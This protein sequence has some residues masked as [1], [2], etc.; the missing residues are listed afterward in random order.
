MKR[1]FYGALLSAVSFS[2]MA[3][4]YS[5]QAEIGGRYNYTD[6]VFDDDDSYSVYGSYYF[7]PVQLKNHAYAEAA[8]LERASSV[9]LGGTFADNSF[10]AYNVCAASSCSTVPKNL[11]S[12]NY[13]LSTRGYVLDSI[14]YASA[15]YNY[16]DHKIEYS[17]GQSHSGSDTHWSAQLGVAPLEGWLLTTGFSED[18]ALFED[19][20]NVHSKYVGEL[21]NGRAYNLEAG[22]ADWDNGDSSWTVGGDFYFTRAVSVGGTVGEDDVYSL[23]AQ[24]FFT[25][26]VSLSVNLMNSE[27]A[28]SY[29][30]GLTARF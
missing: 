29:S 1:I 25:P 18:S 20:W 2:A 5:Y 10:T 30:V 27:Y 24:S 7:S 19:G 17:N 16:H 12:Q 4:P 6:G 14:I 21:T 23:R 13:S 3:D 11:Q 9:T 22:Y 8:F 15:T 26:N 28:D